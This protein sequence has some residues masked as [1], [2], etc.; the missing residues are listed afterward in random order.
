MSQVERF[1][2]RYVFSCVGILAVFLLVNVLIIGGFLIA[3][4]FKGFCHSKFSIDEFSDHIQNVD[5]KIEAE[6]NVHDV[7]TQTY[8]WAMLLN[9]EGTII[10]EDR[11]PEKL[12]HQYSITDV[13]MFSRW[14][15]EE[16]PVNIWN[17]ADGLL[18]VGFLP[19]KVVQHY[20]SLDMDDFKMLLSGIACATLINLFL[21]ILLFIRN[22]HR[23][24]KAM[25]PILS[26]IHSL[27]KGQP[28]CLDEDGELAEISAEL[29]SAGHYL[30]KKDNTRS[31]WIRGVSHDV[32]TPLS[33]ILGYAS[34]MKEDTTLPA[35]T[36]KQANLICLQSEKLR[37]LIADLNLTTKL[38]YSVIA[39]KSEQ[40]APVE[41]AR[42]V[43]CEYL[44]SDLPSKYNL[45]L[46]EESIGNSTR[47]YGDEFLLMRMLKNLIQNSILHNPNGCK[48]IVSIETNY[49]SCCFTVTDDGTG[50]DKDFL[51]LLNK[52]ICKPISETENEIEHGIGLRVVRQI[53]KLHRGTLYF[54]NIQ[55]HGLSVKITIPKA[56]K[57][58][59][60]Q[61]Q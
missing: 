11:L 44:N 1:F 53:V 57:N 10:W 58:A 2:R 42:Q 39:V 22:T 40:I 32:R 52:N 47:L 48:I 4:Y 54:S 20:S 26:G 34:Q 19:D 59:A 18:V 12:K 36:R 29:N 56:L 49:S 55:P 13:A 7:L 3:S 33:M 37:D 17:R 6:E 61:T 38:E 16:Y 43:I 15:L 41:L 31:E 60:G 46:S 28:I 9:D 8:S 21:I 5:G 45:C 35:E 50:L 24:E 25:T 23:I 30:Q 14:Y 27:S 51:E